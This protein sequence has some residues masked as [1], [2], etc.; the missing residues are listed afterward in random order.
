MNDIKISVIVPVYNTR[1]FLEKCLD[2]ICQQTLKEIEI[3]CINDE[4]KDNSD[5]ILEQY[6]KRDSR[7]KIFN[8]KH[9][10][11]GAASARNLGLS[12]ATGTYLSFL[13]S[14]DYFDCTMLQKVY[15]KAERLHTDIV[16][17]DAQYFDNK[18]GKEI[19][20][21]DV[22]QLPMFPRKEVFS[23]YD[24]P[25]E[26]FISTIGAAW[27]ML[28]RHDFI[29]K[30]QLSFQ[31]LY[32]ADDFFFVYG[33]LAVAER[34]GIINEKLIFYRKGNENSQSANK[35][36][37]PLAALQACKKLK[38]WLGEKKRYQ[39]YEKGFHN[40]AARYCY[41]YM[42][43]MDKCE[44]FISLYDAFKKQYFHEFGFDKIQE[45]ELVFEFLYDWIQKIG[46]YT[47][48]EYL[49]EQ[50]YKRND[51]FVFE[52]KKLF[53]KN[54]IKPNEKIILYGAGNMGKAYYVQN[55]I[56]S[57]CNVVGWI[58][59]KADQM[60]Q[61]IENFDSIFKKSF[62][63]ILIAIE[64]KEVCKQVQRDLIQSGIEEE[65]IIWGN[66]I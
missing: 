36:I 56:N 17:Y 32:H 40:V 9:I 53:P 39:L 14:D 31:S 47:K 8:N 55:I 25:R 2:S 21:N 19:F 1:P 48:E 65:K 38:D 5:K 23:G 61:P 34:I 45:G 16:M 37:A 29:K 24:F 18:T 41:F 22:L 57:Y 4:S 11:Y 51:F 20:T 12:K 10:G 60:N 7:I 59:K 43:T 58:D 50:M 54:F 28:F 30:H 49:F 3:I 13:D 6:A 26:I 52:T 62:D 46:K 27:S 35:S 33:A 15:E 44:N 64:S 42:E 63:K 66:E